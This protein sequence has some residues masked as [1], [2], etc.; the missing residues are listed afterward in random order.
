MSNQLNTFIMKKNPTCVS[1]TPEEMYLELQAERKQMCQNAFVPP[2]PNNAFVS[3]PPNKEYGWLEKND[4]YII[5]KNDYPTIRNQDVCLIIK[6]EIA[7]RAMITKLLPPNKELSSA[8]TGKIVLKLIKDAFGCWDYINDEK[9]KNLPAFPEIL[10]AKIK[11]APLSPK[12][13][14]KAFELPNAR[15]IIR[16][17]AAKWLYLCPKADEKARKLGWL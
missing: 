14:L 4:K 2:L 17:Q 12:E 11:N 9:I 8:K 3:A 15:K 10:W 6:K 16:K 1:T 13:Q 5:Y 7:K